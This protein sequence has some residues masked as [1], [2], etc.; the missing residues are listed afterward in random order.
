MP[1]TR[2]PGFP[3][4][5]VTSAL[6]QEIQRADHC[7]GGGGVQ[8]IRGAAPNSFAVKILTSKSNGL[9]ILQGS[10]AKPAPIK[11]FRGGGPGGYLTNPQIS[12]NETRLQRTLQEFSIKF[13]RARK[14]FQGREE[15]TAEG[16]S[17]RSARGKSPLRANA[18]S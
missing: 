14:N 6:V 4:A 13:F 10:F 9:N 18:A 1:S 5:I 16:N 7:Q 11:A 3:Q 8:E 12:Q 15:K 17:G 2:H